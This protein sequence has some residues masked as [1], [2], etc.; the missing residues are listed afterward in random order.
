MK[1]FNSRDFAERVGVFWVEV[2][3]FEEVDEVFV[4]GDYQCG[5]VFAAV[6]DHA[7]LADE[8]VAD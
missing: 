2:V 6:A 5:E 8:F 3:L 1:A 7:R 4:V